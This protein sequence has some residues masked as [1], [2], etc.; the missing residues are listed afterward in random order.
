MSCFSTAS[1]HLNFLSIG[2]KLA[3]RTLS[4][5]QGGPINIYNR[6]TIVWLNAAGE[7]EA[8]RWQLLETS[9][10][11]VPADASAGVFVPLSRIS[12]ALLPLPICPRTCRLHGS[13]GT[14]A[15]VGTDES[16]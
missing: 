7:F 13:T 8:V 2:S 12:I 10:V 15:S 3:S 11:S 1:R 4:A 14:D 6:K 5:T 16:V 9:L